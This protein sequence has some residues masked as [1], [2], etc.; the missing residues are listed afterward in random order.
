MFEHPSRLEE[1]PTL[2]ALVGSF[3]LV[4]VFAFWTGFS[5][6]LFFAWC[7]CHYAALLAA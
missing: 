5:L 1:M 4:G 7:K 3:Q 2:A 6:D